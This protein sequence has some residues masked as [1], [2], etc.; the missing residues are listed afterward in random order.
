MSIESCKIKNTDIVWI[1]VIDPK[2]G[3]LDEISK[4][5]N[6]NTYTLLDSLDPDHLPKYEEHNDT[7]FLILRI[8]EDGH[9]KEPSIQSLSSKIAIFFNDE[10]IITVHRSAQPI[11]KNIRENYVDNGKILTACGI[12]IRI[13]R[14]TFHTYEAPAMALSDK[15]DMYESK[16]FL[17]NTIKSN[18]IRSI[19]FLKNKAGI[20][21]KL[22]VL[23]NEVI[24]S[25]HVEGE[26]RPALRDV[27]DLH[28]K[29][30]LLYD[31]VL[32]DTAN[33]L[34]VYLSLSSQKTNEVMKVLTI[35]SVFFMPLTFI[36]GVYGMN[37]KYMPELNYKWGYPLS[38]AI[39]FL[40]CVVVFIIFKRKKWM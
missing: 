26:E 6:L 9:P 34:N 21:K 13:I 19:Y 36:V 30:L 29:L 17:K 4:A 5:Y 2:P 32:D 35:L 3:E 10:F 40:V 11:I 23:S 8:L 33:L 39:M 24:S 14:E 38:W 18:M 31:Q 16:L 20:Y 28:T 22:L 37:F 12:V 27:K 7:H 25:L 15:I 1:D